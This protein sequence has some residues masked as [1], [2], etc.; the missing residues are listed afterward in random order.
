MNAEEI[1]QLATVLRN[2]G[3]KV[4]NGEGKLSLSTSL[5][6]T[7]NGSFSLVTE[8]RDSLSS[9]FQ[10]LTSNSN[11]EMFGDLRFLHDFVQRSRSLK[12][13]PSSDEAADVS[14]FKNLKFLELNKVSADWVVGIQTLRAKLKFIVCIRSVKALKDVLEECGG[15]KCSGFLWN[16]LRGAV[17]SYNEICSLDASLEL[18]PWLHTLDLS[19]NNL[20]SPIQLNCLSSLKYLN[21]SYNKLEHV[22]KFAGQIC[23]RL[24][25][26]STRISLSRQELFNSRCSS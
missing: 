15:D 13:I 17:F 26:K 18:T 4:L 8:Q 23:N 1:A 22:P 21:L 5:L 10:V 19:H 20:K 14:L 2:N 11:A 3:D 12:L 16:E 24:Q 7:L 25:V 9:S 6:N